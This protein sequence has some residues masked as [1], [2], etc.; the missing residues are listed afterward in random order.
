[1]KY[2]LVMAIFL[3][4]VISEAQYKKR[5]QVTYTIT[6]DSLTLEQANKLEDVL[7]HD[8]TYPKPYTVDI[9]LEDMP[10]KNIWNGYF[11]VDTIGGLNKWN[12]LY[13]KN[14]IP[15]TY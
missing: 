11:K 13:P 8:T 7:R 3:G 9:K 5:F 15:L 12:N 14:Y 6:V 4:V 1:M 10:Q 2:L